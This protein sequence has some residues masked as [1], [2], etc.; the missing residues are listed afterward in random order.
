MEV[1][2]CVFSLFTVENW[3]GCWWSSALWT[4]TPPQARLYQL[5]LVTTL[6]YHSPS[7]FVF[8]MDTFV[9]LLICFT[10][11]KASGYNGLGPL[12][13]TSLTIHKGNLFPCDVGVNPFLSSELY[14]YLQSILEF[15]RHIFFLIEGF[16]S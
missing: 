14:I 12:Y 4:R 15:S 11:Q 3:M 2:V 5:P 6:N 16:D 10:T 1:N 7:A 13:C 8:Q 9:A